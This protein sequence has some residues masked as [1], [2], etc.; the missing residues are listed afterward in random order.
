MSEW[1]MRLKAQD[2]RGKERK[3]DR[4]APLAE[5]LTWDYA[6]CGNIGVSRIGD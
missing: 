5:L 4:I 3:N 1:I 2:E 6:Y